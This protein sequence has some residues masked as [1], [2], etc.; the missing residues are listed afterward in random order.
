MSPGVQ[1]SDFSLTK[2]SSRSQK[3][4]SAT[5]L[6]S[7][8]S[9]LY[10]TSDNKHGRL[11][12]AKCL[13]GDVG[14]L[15]KQRNHPVRKQSH[16]KVRPV[17]TRDMGRHEVSSHLLPGIR[18]TQTPEL[19][20]LAGEGAF[21]S[22]V[23]LTTTNRNICVSD[24]PSYLKTCMKRKSKPPANLDKCISYMDLSSRNRD[25][26]RCTTALIDDDKVAPGPRRMTRNPNINVN[27]WQG[28]FMHQAAVD[29][30]T[31]GNGTKSSSVSRNGSGRMPLY[32]F[33]GQNR[34]GNN[35]DAKRHSKTRKI[36]LNFKLGAC[37]LH[38]P[39]STVDSLVDQRCKVSKYSKHNKHNKQWRRQLLRLSQDKIKHALGE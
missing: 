33:R 6:V 16:G 18:K 22:F 9:S 10:M 25:V 39:Q 8:G 31:F 29:D 4:K 19:K 17:A 34:D 13:I 12:S 23:K 15:K 36:N 3:F 37:K 27:S 26:K 2:K 7:A 14:P 30:I 35:E 38:K 11:L 20:S 5:S 28:C 24:Q 32:T 21:T 1:Y